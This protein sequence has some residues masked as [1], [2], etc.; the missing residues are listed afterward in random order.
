M[1][2]NIS[3]F[4]AK[5]ES[6]TLVSSSF[7]LT[8]NIILMLAVVALYLWSCGADAYSRS[9]RQQ[10]QLLQNS[11]VCMAEYTAGGCDAL[12]LTAKCSEL[13][14]CVQLKEGGTLKSIGI[15]ALNLEDELTKDYHFA[16]VMLA[17]L[18]AIRLSSTLKDMALST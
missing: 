13:L 2:R 7:R 12:G 4:H 11:K 8:G 15:F 9:E 16:A 1:P 14:N 18:F 10:D 17:F 3:A 5:E 6:S